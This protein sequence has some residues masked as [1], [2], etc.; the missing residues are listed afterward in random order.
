M[1]IPLINNRL[2]QVV[3]KT[4]KLN[5]DEQIKKE[6]IKEQLIKIQ[7][8]HLAEPHKGLVVDMFL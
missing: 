3:L 7:L 2:Y 5:I 6:L 8:S 1:N 4:I